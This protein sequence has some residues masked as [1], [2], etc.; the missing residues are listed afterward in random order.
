IEAYI[1]A[2]NFF[3][4]FLNGELV[5]SD[6]R[7][8]PHTAFQST[9][10]LLPGENI[11]AVYLRDNADNSTG[12]EYGDRCVGDGGFR[13]RA[14]DD[15]LV[16]SGEWKCRT[17]FYGPIN[18]EHVTRAAWMYTDYDDSQWDQAIEFPEVTV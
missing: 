14:L 6:T 3:D 4:L 8:L 16:S 2:D 11:I 17:V 10:K 15:S 12:L 13:F 9:L 5:S 1:Y 7:L 18:P